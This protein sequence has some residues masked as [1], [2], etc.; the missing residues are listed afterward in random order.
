MIFVAIL[1]APTSAQSFGAGKN[2]KKKSH[3]IGLVSQYWNTGLKVIVER[4]KSGCHVQSNL[5]PRR[6]DSSKFR[7]NFSR[8]VGVVL[9]PT[10]EVEFRRSSL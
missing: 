6:L 7:R 5:L 8:C 1:A 9:E 3:R 10:A 2:W 4:E